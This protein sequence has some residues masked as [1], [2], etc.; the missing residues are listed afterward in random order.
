MKALVV[1]ALAR[2]DG[3]RKVTLDVIGIGPRAVASIVENVIPQATAEI[4]TSETVLHEN[5]SLK[6]YDILLVS[7]MTSDIRVAKRIVDKWRR[8]N[9]GPAI[10]GGPITSNPNIVR[11]LGYDYGVYGEAEEPLPVLLKHILEGHAAGEAPSIEG[12]IVNRGTEISFVQRKIYTPRNKLNY[13]H[14][15][16]IEKYPFYWASRVYVEIVRGCSNFRR[17]AIRLADGRKCIHCPICY[18]PRTPLKARLH[19]PLRIPAGCGYCSVPELYGPARSRSAN[20][21]VAEIRKLV[22]KGVTRIVLSAP[23]ILDYGRDFLVEPEPLTDPCNPRANITMLRKL[24]SS[25]WSIPEVSSGEVVI[26]LENIKACLVDEETAKL[27]GEFFQGTPVH[28][29]AESGDDTHL[30]LI[31]RPS[32]T[33]DVRRAVM[34]L[35]REG[36]QPYVYFI[37]GLPGETKKTVEKTIALMEELAALGAEKITAYKFRPL[38]GTA[39]EGIQARITQH[40]LRIR[41]TARKLNMKLKKKIIGETMR[42]IVAGYNPKRKMLVAYPIPHGPVILI[43]SGSELI[44]WLVEV[45]ILDVISDR[46]TLGVVVR[47]IRRKGHQRKA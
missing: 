46:E 20:I 39:F 32:L 17:P 40:S 16:R 27:L 43:P 4:Y 33:E 13:V 15:P 19:C 18:D 34:Y 25:I 45:K 41:D 35:S 7:A 30:R 36:L 44:G 22:E 10:I 14:S 12:V 28:I 38:P 11:S 42:A 24:F 21:I 8:E 26:M 9:K 5:F 3:R 47:K 1:D 31:G 2:G 29:G 37:Y 6:D 23:D